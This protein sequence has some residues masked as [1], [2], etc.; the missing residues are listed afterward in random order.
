MMNPAPQNAPFSSVYPSGQGFPP[1]QQIPRQQ[2]PPMTQQRPPAG[3]FTGAPQVSTWQ[4]PPGGGFAGGYAAAGAH[5]QQRPVQGQRQFYQPT[6]NGYNQFSQGFPQPNQ[7]FPN[8]RGGMGWQGGAPAGAMYGRGVGGG[9]QMRGAFRPRGRKR[10]FVGG[11]LESQRQWEQTTLC[12]FYLQNQCKFAEG[13]R[14]LHQDDP[15]KPCQF[16][17]GCR[18]GHGSRA[19]AQQ[20][21]SP[22]QPAQAPS[23][24]ASAEAQQQHM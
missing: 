2:S 5:Y 24:P 16:G 14:F 15:T 22:T 17:V 6:P 9:G 11:S 1:N 10:P 19:P 20:N 13:C 3:Q 21:P 7:A 23:P 18:A 8:R 4:G 12:C